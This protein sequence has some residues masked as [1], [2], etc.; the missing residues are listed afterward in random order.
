MAYIPGIDLSSVQGPISAQDFATMKARGSRFA[1]AKCGNGNNAQP[2][3]DALVYAPRARAAG[4]VFGLYHFLYVGL[5]TDPG[6][7]NRDPE[8]QATLH[9]AQEEKI[10]QP[11]DLITFGDAE[12]PRP[13]NWA[14]WQTS[15]AYAREWLLRYRDKYVTLSGRTLGFYFDEGFMRA[16]KPS[17]EY[18]S[19]PAWI[20]SWAP[21]VAPIFPWPGWSIWQTSGGGGRLPDGAPVDTDVIADEATLSMLVGNPVSA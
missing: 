5:P 11:G 21:Y 15:Q 2:D 8:G 18:A 14:R 10:W 3:P 20:A 13:E 19:S 7:P 9:W 12:W 6:H 16:V 17:A 1:V 4:F